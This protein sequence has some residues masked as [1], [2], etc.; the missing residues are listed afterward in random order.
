MHDIDTGPQIT[1]FMSN[2]VFVNNLY[3]FYQFIEVLGNF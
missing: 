1:F 2:L 3:L